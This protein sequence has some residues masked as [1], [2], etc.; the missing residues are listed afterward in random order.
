MGLSHLPLVEAKIV[1]IVLDHMPRQGQYSQAANVLTVEQ[2]NNY[3]AL[4]RLK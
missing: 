3:A 2:F 4:V 1:A